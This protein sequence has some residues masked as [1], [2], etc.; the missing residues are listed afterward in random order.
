MHQRPLVAPEVQD[1]RPHAAP[2]L[3]AVGAGVVEAE[4]A[5]LADGPAHR[6]DVAGHLLRAREVRRGLE[7]HAAQSA[8]PR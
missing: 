3:L 1:Q 5:V 4:P 6:V 7:H 8:R 2:G